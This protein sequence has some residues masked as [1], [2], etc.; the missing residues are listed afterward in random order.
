MVIGHLGLRLGAEGQVPLL[1]ALGYR[2]KA[3]FVQLALQHARKE[4]AVGLGHGQLDG[5]QQGG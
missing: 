2:G 3:E 4:A 5:I 1:C